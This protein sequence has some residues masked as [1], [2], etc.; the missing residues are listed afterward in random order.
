M[1]NLPDEVDLPELGLS[2]SRCRNLSLEEVEGELIAV[3]GV[4]G[5]G[6]CFEREAD[7]LLLDGLGPSEASMEELAFLETMEKV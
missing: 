1:E 2:L 4:Y 7:A 6:G 5:R 3:A